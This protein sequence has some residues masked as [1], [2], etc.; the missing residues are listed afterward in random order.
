M[1]RSFFVRGRP[2]QNTHRAG[3]ERDQDRRK[4]PAS[5]E[6]GQVTPP[7]REHSSVFRLSLLPSWMTRISN[8]IARRLP[9]LRRQN[10]YK[11]VV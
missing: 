9:T 3:Y 4:G 1:G 2:I 8:A 6:A 5:C 10:E 7:S 11:K